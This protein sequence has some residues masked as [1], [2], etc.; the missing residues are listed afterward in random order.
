MRVA[1][2]KSFVLAY[3]PEPAFTYPK[4]HKKQPETE[5][6]SNITE[7]SRAKRERNRVD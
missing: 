6:N 7:D 5:T 1:H 4:N 3:S 2:D